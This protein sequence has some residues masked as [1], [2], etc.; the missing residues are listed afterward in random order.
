MTPLGK[1]LREKYRTP[2]AAMRALGLDATL[3]KD[4]KEQVTMPNI[5]LTRKAAVVY[6]ALAGYLAPKM[7]KDTKID[8]SPILA[9]IDKA[10]FKEQR[11]V[12]AAALRAVAT[13]KLKSGAVIGDDLEATLLA[14]DAAEPE[15]EEKKAKKEGEDESEE[16]RKKREA[17]DKRAKD[18]RAADRKARDEE[19]KGFLKEKMKAEDYKAAC[20]MIDK[21]ARDEGEGES[22]S[23]EEK[24]KREKKEGEDRKSAMDAALAGMVSKTAMDAAIAKASA[25]ATAK[26][27]STAAAIRVAEE[28]VRPIVGKIVVACDSAEAVYRTACQMKG[29]DITGKHPDAFWPILEAKF[30]APQN[31][32][33]GGKTIA[34]DSASVADFAKRFPNAARIRASA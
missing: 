29:I 33:G 3:L 14:L 16:E 15:E 19:V 7:A 21:R 13:P 4:D 22:E 1:A 20:D 27:L 2:H 34:Q 12:I 30:Q 25:E 9:S 18:K 10:N 31:L 11:P 17:D 26:A 5:V 8:L 32:G 28:N 24:R 23:E 6:G